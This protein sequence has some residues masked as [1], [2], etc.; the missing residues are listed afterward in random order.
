[1]PGDRMDMKKQYQD[2]FQRDVSKAE[3]K[4]ETTPKPT[5]TMKY[6]DEMPLT[7][8]EQWRRHKENKKKK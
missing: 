4:I 7:V 5:S 1:M 2:P 6:V 3:P 8:K